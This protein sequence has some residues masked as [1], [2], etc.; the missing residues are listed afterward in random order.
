V[1]G[2]AQEEGAHE[3]EHGDLLAAPSRHDREA[4]AGRPVAEVGRAQEAGALFEERDEVAM[5]P[6]V[7]ACCDN[8]CA[9]REELLRQLRREADSVCRVLSV[10][11]TEVGVELVLELRQARLDRAPPRSTEDVREKEDSQFAG[12]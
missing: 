2:H 12:N 10:D 3:V 5:S 9:G 11:N 4:A 6:D 1:D 8:I 7:V